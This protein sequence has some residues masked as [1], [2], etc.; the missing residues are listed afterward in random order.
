MQ[1]VLMDIAK[2]AAYGAGAGAAT[3][4]IKQAS[5]FIKEQNSEKSEE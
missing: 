3:E 4:A 5:E 2:A 1:K